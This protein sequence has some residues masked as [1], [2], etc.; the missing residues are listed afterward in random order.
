[1]LGNL[2]ELTK[3]AEQLKLNDYTGFAEIIQQMAQ[4]FK[5]QELKEF[6]NQ[7]RSEQ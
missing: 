1:M 4:E 5:V 3:Q 6:I 7:H 2:K